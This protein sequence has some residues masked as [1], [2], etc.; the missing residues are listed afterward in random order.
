[1]F[2]NLLIDTQFSYNMDI[3]VYHIHSMESRASN[4]GFELQ[5]AM[6]LTHNY[7]VRVKL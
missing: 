2:E 7:H 5:A 6:K 1:M 3:F 4:F